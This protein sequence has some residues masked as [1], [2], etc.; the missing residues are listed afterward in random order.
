MT[1]ETQQPA[2]LCLRKAGVMWG[3]KVSLYLFS[4]VRGTKTRFESR[5]RH[6]LKR[7]RPLLN[8]MEI[9]KT[10]ID[11]SAIVIALISLLT[12]VYVIIRDRRHKRIELILTLRDRILNEFGRHEILTPEQ[13][14]DFLE[15]DPDSEE[16][17]KHKSVSFDIQ[18]KVEREIDFVCYLVNKGEIDT[19][20]F[21]DIFRHWIRS[22]YLFWEEHQTW[23]K[24]NYPNTWRLIERCIDKGLL[25]RKK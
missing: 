21:F 14:M 16:A 9:D 4:F 20:L 23:K 6:K 1:D 13:S 17:Q 22:R 11:I 10:Y 12:S 2:T 5:S 24:N 18:L 25:E 7:C 8:D 19:K 15:I 3:L